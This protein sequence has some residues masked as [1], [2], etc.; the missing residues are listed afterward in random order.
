MNIKHTASVEAIRL[1]IEWVDNMAKS[2]HNT[3]GGYHTV[4]VTCIEGFLF[5]KSYFN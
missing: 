3:Q 5:D 1:S 4:T 2:K